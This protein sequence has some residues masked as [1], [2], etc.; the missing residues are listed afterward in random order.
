M[1]SYHLILASSETKPEIKI[2]LQVCSVSVRCP[3][4]IPEG[5]DETGKKGIH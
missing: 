4:E 3:Q 5:K 1:Y 2:G